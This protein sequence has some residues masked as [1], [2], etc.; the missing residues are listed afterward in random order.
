MRFL[1]HAVRAI[2]ALSFA[3]AALA[4]SPALALD[5]PLPSWND[6]SSKDAIINF[7]TRVTNEGGEDFVAP[8]E[9]IAVFDNDGTLWAEQPIYFQL[10]FA[11][12]RIAALAPEHPKWH[13]TEPFKGIIEGDLKAVSASGEHGLLEIMAATHAGLTTEKFGAIVDSWL[14]GAQHPKT[15]RLYTEMVYQP[16][17]ELLAYLRA[18]GFKTF[19]VSGGGTEFMRRFAEKV[20]GIPPEQ[21]I[22]STGVVKFSI[23]ADG[24]PILT[25]EAKVE[26]VDDG[27]GK[28][29]GINRAIGR[30]PIFAFGN[31]DGDQQMLEWTAGGTGARFMGLVHHTDADREWAYDRTSHIGK[32]D[33]ALDE[34]AAKGW[35]VVDMKTDWKSVFPPK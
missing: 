24:K 34:A 14:A 12:D 23:D 6:T 9:R 21:V 26:F 20:Y 22:G 13:D 31:S 25:K 15:K 32:L 18:N 2:W 10:A 4:L 3:L 5:D 33:K 19:I 30:R 7:V 11:I 17:L 1:S 16:M 8:A 29:V 35:T 28:P 27:P